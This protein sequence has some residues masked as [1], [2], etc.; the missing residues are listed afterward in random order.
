MA[1]FFFFVYLIIVRY[2]LT[3]NCNYSIVCLQNTKGN[4]NV[5]WP[6]MELEAVHV[7]TDVSQAKYNGDKDQ[8][9][10]VMLPKLQGI[11]A[12]TSGRWIQWMPVH[13]DGR[14][15]FTHRQYAVADGSP[16]LPRGIS[17]NSVTGEISGVWEPAESEMFDCCRQVRI[18]TI[19]LWGRKIS[20]KVRM[21][22]YLTEHGSEH[23]YPSAYA[24]LFPPKS[25][26][27]SPEEIQLS[28]GQ[29]NKLSVMVGVNVKIPSERHLLRGRPRSIEWRVQEILQTCLNREEACV[30]LPK[31]V[32]SQLPESLVLD[33]DT[34]D[35]SG[36]PME[37]G[38]FEVTIEVLT[39]AGSSACMLQ[40]SVL[41]ADFPFGF[42]YPAH[43]SDGKFYP[44]HQYEIG[45]QVRI[46]PASP[47]QCAQYQGQFDFK[48][49]PKLPDGWYLDPNTGVIEGIGK[50]NLPTTQFVVTALHMD[51]DCCAIVRIKVAPKVTSRCKVDL[52]VNGGQ[53]HIF[54]AG[55]SLCVKTRIYRQNYIGNCATYSTF[56]ALPAGLACDEDGHI[57]GIPHGLHPGV[58]SERS[59]ESRL[60][61]I[62]LS[63]LPT[64]S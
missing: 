25:L 10:L 21:H 41:K 58:L 36:V 5:M 40:L 14:G 8:H 17:L 35:L 23:P 27:L 6:Y 30:N 57:W 56:P 11:D 4:F 47:P 9:R 22:L 37:A 48:I 2:I 51:A 28:Y 64:S 63:L 29:G 42:Q 32:K 45:E 33:P 43:R 16:N 1:P 34:G 44:G 60:Q 55:K 61:V 3:I 50:E 24:V 26:D 59:I 15:P 13:K 62:C 53:E 18:E 20:S 52:Q 31:T 54:E 7:K 49:H 46:E 38:D 19:G 12:V 39:S